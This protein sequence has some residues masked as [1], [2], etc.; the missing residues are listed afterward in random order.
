MGLFFSGHVGWPAFFQFLMILLRTIEIRDQKCYPKLDLFTSVD[1]QIRIL[2]SIF[3]VKART[4]R[5]DGIFWELSIL[6]TNN[7]TI[8]IVASKR[9]FVNTSCAAPFEE[10]CVASAISKILNLLRCGVGGISYTPQPNT[11]CASGWAHFFDTDLKW[12]FSL[13]MWTDLF[14]TVVLYA[15]IVC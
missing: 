3:C 14:W 10:I 13:Y 15:K 2:I 9:A 7:A 1:R 4:N 11:H 12:M 8:P 6:K 5:H